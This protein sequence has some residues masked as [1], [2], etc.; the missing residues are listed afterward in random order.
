MQR[1]QIAKSKLANHYSSFGHDL[2]NSQAFSDM[3]VTLEHLHDGLEEAKLTNQELQQQISNLSNRRKQ[4]K[5][6]LSSAEQKLAAIE[7]SKLWQIQTT[8]NQFKKKI[9]L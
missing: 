3:R 7:S 9:G 6:R 8:F 4:L 5:K 1:K 2:Q